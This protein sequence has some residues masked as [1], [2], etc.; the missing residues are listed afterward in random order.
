MR[1]DL[2]IHNAAVEPARH[3]V[4]VGKKLCLRLQDE[5]PL[6][7]VRKFPGFDIRHPCRRVSIAVHVTALHKRGLFRQQLVPRQDTTGCLNLHILR[8][9]Q[10]RQDILGP[11]RP[12]IL[13]PM[14]RIVE[15]ENTFR[16]IAHTNA[17]LVC[18]LLLGGLRQHPFNVG[19]GAA[20][21]INL[22]PH[23]RAAQRVG[24]VARRC[25]GSG[26]ERQLFL[27]GE[28]LTRRPGILGYGTRDS[29][30][31][32]T[33]PLADLRRA[34]KRHKLGGHVDFDVRLPDVLDG[35]GR[36]GG[37]LVR[38][39]YGTESRVVGTRGLLGIRIA[40]GNV[41]AE[42]G[43]KIGEVGV[44]LGHAVDDITFFRGAKRELRN[45]C[46]LKLGGVLGNLGILHL[47]LDEIPR[48]AHGHRRDVHTVQQ[49]VGLGHFEIDG[50]HIGTGRNPV[51]KQQIPDA[52][53]FLQHVLHEFVGIG[54][55]KVRHEGVMQVQPAL[56]ESAARMGIERRRG[57]HARAVDR[58]H[59]ASVIA[60]AMIRFK[61]GSAAPEHENFS[62]CGFS[63]VGQGVE[64]P[65]CHRDGVI[66]D[67][68][69]APDEE[70]LVPHAEGVGV[71]RNETGFDDVGSVGRGLLAARK[72][73][74]AQSAGSV[75]TY[76]YMDGLD[77]RKAEEVMV[78]HTGNDTAAFARPV[79]IGIR[80]HGEIGAQDGRHDDEHLAV[81]PTV[82]L[83]KRTLKVAEMD[84]KILRRHMHRSP[85]LAEVDVMVQ[86]CA[87]QRS[88]RR[89]LRNHAAQNETAQRRH[90]GLVH[91]FEEFF[92][93]GRP[94]VA[95][96]FDVR[97]I[98]LDVLICGV[99]DGQA[100]RRS[101]HGIRHKLLVLLI[102]AHGAD[103]G[104][105]HDLDFLC[106]FHDRSD[107]L[108][109]GDA[110]QPV[111][112]I[113]LG[114]D[115]VAVLDAS[116]RGRFHPVKTARALENCHVFY[117]LCASG[118]TEPRN[119]FSVLVMCQLPGLEQVEQVAERVLGSVRLGIDRRAAGSLNRSY[120]H[121]GFGR[122]RL[123]LQLGQQVD[124]KR[125]VP[126]L[127]LGGCELISRHV[128]MR[129]NRL[130]HEFAIG[131]RIL[132]LEKVGMHPSNFPV[133]RVHIA[134]QKRIFP[135]LRFLG[136]LPALRFEV[137]L[138]PS[139]EVRLRSAQNSLCDSF[140]V[141]PVDGL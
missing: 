50:V 14:F 46:G 131:R 103:F 4:G 23:N 74:E 102:R 48:T 127:V 124:N 109:V 86:P 120:S 59:I 47:V 137:L 99:T 132:Q 78:P 112:F 62:H 36:P 3:L 98:E 63:L 135:A 141:F 57:I 83:D 28:L 25:G 24:P 67:D 134:L 95:R 110:R 53:H 10:R 87:G 122:S 116:K 54:I 11:E 123:L 80:A 13:V 133:A 121:D 82:L 88:L 77:R 16:G 29:R 66:V 9:R 64:G 76:R 17:P 73:V 140:G 18:L 31:H 114:N 91:G 96:L 119:L 37:N 5:K 49:R 65:V 94:T 115:L 58:L 136:N 55:E 35:F 60:L 44:Q 129:S 42:S 106:T 30:C 20:G 92:L 104:S 111:L 85:G 40:L 126:A 71:S 19:C 26:R 139:D 100:T 72:N 6:L 108:G 101:A 1:F 70:V 105:V 107:E 52:L 93:I 69:R 34:V 32:N 97:D 39:E 118:G 81:V 89:Y 41:V 130:A 61:I 51:R 27:D 113:N 7:F 68:F 43:R 75:H 90:R 84:D 8:P 38:K 138:Q 45:A 15:I 12:K 117:S 79:G 22:H 125:S 21:R 2:F 56:P 128:A 33:P